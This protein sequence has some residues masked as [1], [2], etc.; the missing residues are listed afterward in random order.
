[1]ITKPAT[2]NVEES[3]PTEAE[4]RRILKERGISPPGGESRSWLARRLAASF[5]EESHRISHLVSKL[6]AVEKSVSQL[7]KDCRSVNLTVG[8]CVMLGA[9]LARV[10]GQPADSLRKFADSVLS[11]LDLPDSAELTFSKDEDVDN[12][13]FFQEGKN[14]IYF[15]EFAGMPALYQALKKAVPE[16]FVQKD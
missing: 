5:Q 16:L 4:L 2:S 10:G 3:L 8:E 9:V 14:T 6:E 11:K 15:A 7:D 13:A 1:M 12:K